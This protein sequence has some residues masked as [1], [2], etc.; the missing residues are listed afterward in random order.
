MSDPADQPRSDAPDANPDDGQTL[1]HGEPAHR[2]QTGKPATTLLNLGPT[3]RPTPVAEVLSAD[4][5]NVEATTVSMERSGAENIK[6]ERLTMSYS[7]ANRIDARSAQLDS[8][9]VVSL[10]ADHAVLH[11]SAA[12]SV[13]ARDVRLVKGRTVL[14]R[15]DSATID[16]G[17]RVLIYAG[18]SSA[19]MRPVLDAAGAAAAG[20]GMGLVVLLFGAVMRRLF[21]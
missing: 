5:G 8:S 19:T 6:A 14:L 16:E 20:A 10:Q 7:G 21:R 1:I 13:T 2:S 12:F 17:A 9:G 11:D 3:K 18:P 15:A 4:A